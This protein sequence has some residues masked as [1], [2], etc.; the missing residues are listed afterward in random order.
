[1][2]ITEDFQDGEAQDFT[3]R[4][5]DWTIGNGMYHLT[6]E[7]GRGAAS[8]INL[9]EALPEDF[10]L[11]AVLNAVPGGGGYWTNV[12]QVFDY[13][14][15]EDFKVA[16]GLVGSGKWIVGTYDGGLNI[17]AS[18]S[19]SIERSHDYET[20][21]IFEGKKVTFNV[22]GDTKV[23][24][25]FDEEIND[26]SVGLG[27]INGRASFDDVLLKA[28]IPGPEAVDDSGNTL[29]GQTVRINLLANDVEIQGRT[30]SVDSVSGASGTVALVDTDSDGA[31]DA[32][33][34]T[35]S[36]DFRGIDTFTYVVKDDAGQ[37]DTGSVSIT[38]AAGMP[39]TEDFEDGE[40]Q[41]FTAISGT[42]AVE[43]S[44]YN[45]TPQ[46]GTNAISVINVGEALPENIEFGATVHALKGSGYWTN[47]MVF[48]DY[49]TADDFK[50]AGTFAGSQSWTIGEYSNGNIVQRTSI[51]DSIAANT[52]YALT[53]L[54]D[55][56]NLA[57]L[58][59]GGEQMAT[60]QFGDDITEGKLGLGTFN[61]KARY[62]D[63]YLKEIDDAMGEF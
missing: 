14:G 27:S 39:I 57:T 1:M 53:L 7:I 28:L 25:T 6:P 60:Y 18:T 56:N 30:N 54:L 41:D 16:G 10:K 45:A 51:R 55:E 62:D 48:F 35:P 8:T 2:P 5:G 33:D 19:E 12:F 58:K 11:E 43:N 49:H 40:A 13:H 37:T 3:P 26:G 17:L 46:L 42:W 20:A 32:I 52:D 59:I 61:A 38:V 34:Y 21:T 31:I 63:V 22:S 50:F 9:G 15:P 24:Y 4:S 36:N 44:Q 23:T 29:V 47:T